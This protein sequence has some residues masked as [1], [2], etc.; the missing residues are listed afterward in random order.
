MPWVLPLVSSLVDFGEIGRLRRRILAGRS[1]LSR[2][3]DRLSSEEHL[4][5]LRG[6][7]VVDALAD[8]DLGVDV[9]APR[10][11]PQALARIGAFGV[12]VAGGGPNVEVLPQLGELVHVQSERQ[13]RL[14][15]DAGLLG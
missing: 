2:L 8:P 11:I 1:E 14:D 15:L 9:L 5:L 6:A 7:D 4:E 12:R 13:G 10:R 3:P